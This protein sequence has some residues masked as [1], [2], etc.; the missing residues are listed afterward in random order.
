M[1]VMD[2]DSFLDLLEEYLD[3]DVIEQKKHDDEKENKKETKKTQTESTFVEED[4][5][6]IS[7]YVNDYLGIPGNCS[8]LYHSGLKELGCEY[9][10]GVDNNFA[11]KNPEL[12]HQGYLLLVID[13][14]HHRGTY[15]NPY[16]LRKIMNKDDV[17]KELKAFS[18]KRQIELKKLSEY[19]KKYL[20]LKAEYDN[21]TK[22]YSL[23]KETHKEK[24]LRKIMKKEDVKN[25]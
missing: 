17:E 21:N 20:E 1:Q 23:L 2:E 16:Y 6:S 12:V 24:Q 8:K 25:D 19:Y 3:D 10:M 5:I 4:S 14:K 13:A 9:V 7:R 18:K 22:F 15:I 11:N